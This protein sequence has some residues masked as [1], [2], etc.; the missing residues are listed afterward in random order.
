L[1]VFAAL[2]SLAQSS[3]PA[4]PK[5]AYS[6]S[7]AERANQVLRVKITLPPNPAPNA[8][9]LPV[10]NA[11]YQ[12]RDFSQYVN[13]VTARDPS[14]NV[15]PL[16]KLNKSLWVFAAQPLGLEVEY[17][18]AA[19][20]AGP[21]GAEA[22]AH[23]AFLNLAQVLM[24]P[25]A[26][27]S[28]PVEVE[29]RDLPEDWKIATPLSGSA[30]A[31]FTAANYDVLVDSPVEIGSFVEQD[32]DEGG[33][34]YRV[35]VDAKRADYDLEKLV[36][37]VR[38]I[39]AAGTGWMQ[40][41]PFSTYLFLY[42]FLP[43]SGGG[44]MEH[45]YST[46]IDLPAET[47]ANDFSELESVTAHEFFH[48]WN[49]K[50][51]IP[52]SLSPVDYT[53]ENYC[54]ALWF[55]EGVTN[56]VESYILLSAG[57]LDEASY[58]K[59]LADRIGELEHR[60]ARL[61]QSVEE[62]SLDAWLEKYD[63]Y[64]APGRSISYYNNGEV[65]GVILDLAMRAKGAGAG[66]LR[67]MFQWMN[68]TYA[69][70]GRS[71]AD[72]EGVRQAAE[73]VSHSDFRALF[74]RYVEGTEEI[75]WNDF[76]APFGW[77]LVEHIARVADPG[78][79]ATRDFDRPPVIQSVRAGGAAARAGASTGDLIVWFN[80]RDV[81]PDFEQRLAEL[82][83]GSTISLRLRNERGESELHW[84]VSTTEQT[85]YELREAAN[86]TLEERARRSAWLKQETA[87]A[88]EARP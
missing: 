80:G 56:T 77:Q 23:H 8:L 63:Y 15:V 10:W 59:R 4:T 30:G 33:G 78:F 87:A 11:L 12:V 20:R 28:S 50:R 22:N 37:S 3:G 48:L 54:R 36:A 82:H 83:P 34:H 57:L 32:F 38:R 17:E 43:R 35:V 71:F 65:L 81:G 1:L 85:E 67:D 51:I 68:R 9:Q 58:R 24:Y 60:P 72:S 70:P 62:S 39:V 7:L 84:Q 25:V 19:N 53:A 75:P 69:Q 66:S 86:V 41:R 55:S 14:G 42:H 74:R 16:R 40:D 2:S 88:K 47:L 49:V 76:F 46:A 27:R 29:F 5:V 44:G 45:A 13:W 21:Y 79:T 18:I 64:R 26:L 61:T 6:V 73:Q 52:Q 31:G